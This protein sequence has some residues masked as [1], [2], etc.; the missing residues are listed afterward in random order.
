MK[1]LRA[2]EPEDLDLM[3]I[4]EN[5]LSVCQYSATTVPLSRY[6]LKCYIEESAGDLFRDS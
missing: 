6:A 4:V 2:I 3:Y 1:Y 5:D